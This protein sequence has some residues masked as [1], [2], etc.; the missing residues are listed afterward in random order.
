[1]NTFLKNTVLLIALMLTF[2]YSVRFEYEFWLVGNKATAVLSAEH[3]AWAISIASNIMKFAIWFALVRFQ[4]R[5]H[6]I[7]LLQFTAVILVVHSVF[8]GLFAS[9]YSFDRSNLATVQTERRAMS[10]Q[11]FDLK[12]KQL[13]DNFAVQNQQLLDAHNQAKLQVVAEFADEKLQWETELE[14]QRNIFKRGSTVDY[15]GPEFDKAKDQLN[16]VSQKIQDRQNLLDESFKTSSSNLRNEF[17]DAM[18]KITNEHTNELAKTTSEKMMDENS[19]SLNAPIIVA[20]TNV[21][22]QSLGWK[23]KPAS[24]V[25]ISSVF[26]NT[27]LELMALAALYIMFGGTVSS[28][29]NQVAP[30]N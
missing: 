11:K 1:M 12:V 25:L 29:E 22:E 14:R 2:T 28:R 15:W 27:L 7:F 21:V 16:L 30:I 8:C 17:N 9:A 3:W 20:F 19:F 23:V 26:I 18:E 6:K 4:E 5:G 10:T 13:K 24:L